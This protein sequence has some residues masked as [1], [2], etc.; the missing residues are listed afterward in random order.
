AFHRDPVASRAFGVAV[1]LKGDRVDQDWAGLFARESE[2]PEHERIQAVSVVTPNDSHADIV[3]AAVDHGFHVICDKPMAT[4]LDAAQAMADAVEKSGRLFALTHTYTGYPMVIEARERVASGQIGQVRRVV[5]S[6]LQDWL[7]DEADTRG[8]VQASWRTDPSRSGEAGALSDIGT[9]ATNLVEFVCGE[10]IVSVAAQLRSVVPGRVLDDDA[11]ALFQLMSGA[12]GTLNVSQVCSGAVN[13]LT[14]EVYGDRGSLA[15]QQ[16]SPNA[17]TLRVRHQ[18]AQLLQPG[19]NVDYLS[20]AARA[21]CR[22]PAGHPEGYIEAFANLYAAFARDVRAFPDSIGAGYAS[23]ADG[24]SAMKFVR[25]A[26]TS[27]Q[28]NARW[29][30]L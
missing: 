29:T 12:A 25:A 1:G 11:G 28:N 7:G 16:E 20:P 2:R 17:L 21:V 22:T 13:G 27:S 5:V 24:V 4:T 9:H 18:P 26:V 3:C 23:A 8:S 30:E 14:L 19:T 6:Y 15:W 10:P